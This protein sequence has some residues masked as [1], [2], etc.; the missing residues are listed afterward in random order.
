MLIKEFQAAKIETKQAKDDAD[1]LIIKTALERSKDLQ[2]A[3]VGQDIDLFVLLLALIPTSKDI[4]F[5]KPKIGKVSLKLFSV[6]ESQK[7]YKDLHNFILLAHAFGGCDT[8]SAIFNKGKKQIL[9]L[10]ATEP[11]LQSAIKI[12][13][14]Y[15]ST[16]D[17]VREAGEILFLN[18]YG[19]KKIGKSHEIHSLDAL[20][21]FLYTKSLDNITQKL[22]TL[23]PTPIAAEY[24]SYRVFLQIQNWIIDSSDSRKCRKNP[25]DW[26]WKK[27]NNILEPIRTTL[28]AAPSSILNLISCGCKASNSCSSNKCSCKRAGIKCSVLCKH[29]QGSDCE[30]RITELPSLNDVMMDLDYE[31]DEPVDEILNVSLES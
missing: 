17:E 10:L 24:H 25:E 27:R 6:H 4:Y 7:K 22:E 19:Y 12:F 16:K 29:C 13:N 11:E 8:T 28:E 26:G 5:L 18:I 1:T 21:Y 2:V 20:R 23:P 31:T 3:V 15:D 9:N 14:K 30:N